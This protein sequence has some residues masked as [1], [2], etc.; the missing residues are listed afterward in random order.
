MS[1]TVLWILFV[2]GLILLYIA[3]RFDYRRVE[4]FINLGGG[5]GGVSLAALT[6]QALDSAP[7]TSEVK[8][9]YKKLLLFAND[10]I[11]KQGVQGLRIL[12]DFR[13]RVYGK[14]DFRD[15]LT[16]EDFLANWPTWMPPLDTSIEEPIPDSA[17]A[18]TAES[19]MLAYLQKNFPQESMVDEQTGSTIRN[20]VEDFGYRFVFKQGSETVQLGPDFLKQPLL[21]NWTNP[22][23][24]A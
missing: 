4:S 19:Q 17:V 11:R 8:M 1:D 3:W 15:N 18:V 2:A 12:A 16:V 20:L 14:R 13:D 7:T 9:H 21:K 24:R 10:D 5:V 23:A 6:T 22:A